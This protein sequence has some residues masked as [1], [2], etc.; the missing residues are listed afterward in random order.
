MFGTVGGTGGSGSGG[1]GRTFGGGSGGASGSKYN[2]S[3]GGTQ[4]VGNNNQA[5]TSVAAVTAVK[6]TYNGLGSKLYLT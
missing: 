1:N 6:M 2:A 5:P 3:Q 4:L